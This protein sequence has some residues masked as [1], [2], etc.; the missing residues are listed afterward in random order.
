MSRHTEPRAIHPLDLPEI[1]THVAQ[2]LKIGDLVRCVRVNK[3]WHSSFIPAL[4]HEVILSPK[5]KGR[6]HSP[7]L[8]SVQKNAYFI[9]LLSLDSKVKPEYL[10]ISFPNLQLLHLTERMTLRGEALANFLTL[11][12]TVTIF[13]LVTHTKENWTMFSKLENVKR[14]DLVDLTVGGTL[15]AD[16]WRFCTRIEELNLN[17]V[18]KTDLMQ[19]PKDTATQAIA[20]NKLIWF[21]R[22]CPN[23]DT[24][25]FP[26]EGTENGRSTALEFVHYISLGTWPKLRGLRFGSEALKDEDTAKALK[27]LKQPCYNWGVAFSGFGPKGFAAFREH[28]AALERV[29]L[30]DCKN[31]TS[32]MIQEIMSSCHLL[33]T[34]VAY[35]VDARVLGNG[36]PWVCR[37]LV[38]LKVCIEFIT[39][40]ESAPLDSKEKTRLQ[41]KIFENLS[42]LRNIESISIGR[43]ASF[44]EA[45][46]FLRPTLFRGLEL[47]LEMGLDLLK[48]LKSLTCFEFQESVQKM[49]RDEADWIV[50]NWVSIETLQ[51]TLNCIDVDIGTQL[52]NILKK[53]RIAVIN[54]YI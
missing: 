53:H 52:Q 41:R 49:T 30:V 31:V 47:R 28:F 5:P 39:T 2:Y 23:L 3:A 29:S 45:K 14:L 8:T 40:T 7:S 15:K 24:A 13:E 50:A 44:H 42:T 11:N 25:E 35:R 37:Q 54:D 43:T 16:F 33:K 34:F 17:V 20:D 22:R 19:I 36:P 48:G 9:R 21:L 32:E 18:D 10:S 26:A 46:P 4:W 1:E 27:S 6:E 38:S 51:G 12:N